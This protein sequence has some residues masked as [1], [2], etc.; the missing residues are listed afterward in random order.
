MTKLL[1]EDSN[2]T[3]ETL[4]NIHDECAIISE[5]E[6][7]LNTYPNEFQIIGSEQMLDAYSSIGLPV[8]YKHW[9]FGKSFMI[10]EHSYRKGRSGLALEMVINSNP[11]I[12]YL[13]EE[14]SATSQALV[15]AH[16]GFGHNHFFKNNYMFKDWTDAEGIVDYLIF[17]RNYITDCEER[18][19]SDT[20]E[21]FIDS[22]H[23][24][25]YHGLDR[26]KRP[27]ELNNKEEIERQVEREEYL[28]QNINVLWNSVVPTA[29]PS[30]EGDM[31]PSEPEENILKFVEKNS[32]H[33]K[34]WQRE[35][36]RI[37]R[38]IQQY[39]YPQSQT[40]VMN[41]GFACWVHNYMMNRLFDKGMLSEGNMLEYLALNGNVVYQRDMTALNPYALGLNIFKD[42]ER[43]CVDPTPEDKEWFPEIA[44]TDPVDTIKNIVENYRDESF[45]RQFLSPKVIRDMR[46]FSLGDFDSNHYVVKDIHNESG[47]RS[48]RKSLADQYCY[49]RHSPDIQI[50]NANIKGDRVL[51]LVHTE[52]NGYQL[53][54]KET[55]SVLKHLKVLWGF[56][57]KLDCVNG[58][59][60]IRKTYKTS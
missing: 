54:D 26:Y 16:A 36:I 32:P 21:A 2:W 41:E 43:I 24:L 5:E 42:I 4:Q 51:E 22:V 10:S 35:V 48:M 1:F 30:V 44:N 57:V 17:A 29:T 8:M 38:R 27:P 6:L 18:Y 60:D 19:G 37:V 12:N 25:K 55:K 20:V 33:L 23:A 14:N 15:I 59:G 7:H 45:I 58:D 52:V 56:P 50:V 28:Q 47:Y 9:S 49:S 53:D 34:L 40:K 39:F 13:M 46:L 3:E 11:C 31:F